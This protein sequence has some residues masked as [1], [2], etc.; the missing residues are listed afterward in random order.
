MDQENQLLAMHPAWARGPR[1][2]D[3]DTARA[4]VTRRL[5]RTMVDNYNT[6]NISNK[7]A[8]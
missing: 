6:M 3:G 5:L 2:Q 7:V 8:D 4:S 1:Q